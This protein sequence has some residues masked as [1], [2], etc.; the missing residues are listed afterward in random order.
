MAAD[1]VALMLALGHQRFAVVGHDRGSYVAYRTALDRPDAVD[2]LVVMDEVPVA[3]TSTASYGMVDAALVRLFCSRATIRNVT[4][5]VSV[6]MISCHVST[7]PTT[8]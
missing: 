6:L 4:I 1:V 8:R 5:V 2:R 3:E 7:L